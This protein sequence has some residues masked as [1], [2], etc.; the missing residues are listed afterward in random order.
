MKKKGLKTVNRIK[1]CREAKGVSQ[2][3]MS[4][5]L[6]TP[7]P[8]ISRWETG[9]RTPS[10]R[11]LSALSDYFGVSTDYLLGIT[12]NPSRSIPT[13]PHISNEDLKF[14]LWGTD[15]ENIT[16]EQFEQVK[17]FARFIAKK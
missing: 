9:E 14:A 7:Q 3:E 5:D 16:K 12:D 10:K 8:V 15:A 11:S 4:I 17:A 13:K 1:A 2:K 6:Q